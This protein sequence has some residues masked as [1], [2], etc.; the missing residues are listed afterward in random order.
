MELY[1]E[2]VKFSNKANVKDVVDDNDN[3]ISIL[4]ISVLRSICIELF[5]KFKGNEY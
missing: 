5:I 3:D 4:A 1:L 2:Q